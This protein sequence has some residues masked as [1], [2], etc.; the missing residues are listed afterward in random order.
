MRGLQPKI[1][2][3]PGQSRNSGFVWG[4]RGMHNRC[5][6]PQVCAWP[7]RLPC[8]THTPHKA[9]LPSVATA[10]KLL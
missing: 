6:D 3:T 8:P 5:S 7:H 9:S 1:L 2:E 4:Q 10:K